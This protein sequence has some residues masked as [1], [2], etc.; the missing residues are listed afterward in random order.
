MKL[1]STRAR[2]YVLRENVS[3]GA[4]LSVVNLVGLLPLGAQG[5]G[6][7]TILG[8]GRVVKV[9]IAQWAH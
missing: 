8:N 6:Q 7:L 9:R 2:S 3:V 1:G 5:G 4:L